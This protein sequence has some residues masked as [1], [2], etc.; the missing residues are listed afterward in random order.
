MV[1]HDTHVSKRDLY[2]FTDA[3]GSTNRV[4]RLDNGGLVAY[5]GAGLVDFRSDVEQRFGSGDLRG[6]A[7]PV[8]A[9]AL[10]TLAGGVAGGGGPSRDLADRATRGYSENERWTATDHADA[11]HDLQYEGNYGAFP[12]T[13]ED[14]DCLLY[15]SDAADE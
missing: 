7:N 14:A 9:G 8:H 2:K 12:A 6:G 13:T 3:R 5:D 4:D 11:E 10:L 15:T 1:R